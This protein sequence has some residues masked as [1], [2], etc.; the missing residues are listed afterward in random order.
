M[1]TITREQA[2]NILL[3][4][5]ADPDEG[6]YEDYSGRSMYGDTCFGFILDVPDVLLGVAIA[7]VLGDDNDAWEMA[8]ATRTD[9]MGRSTIAYFPGWTLEDDDAAECEGHESLD[10]AHMGET[11]YCDGT[12]V[13]A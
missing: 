2:R 10:G 6:L 5:D 3:A 7:T 9:N 13:V 12:C 4:I 1:S 8:R 11:V